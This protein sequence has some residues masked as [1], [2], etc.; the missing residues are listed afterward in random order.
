MKQT[1]KERILQLQQEQDKIQTQLN[2]L[3]Q[4]EYAFGKGPKLKKK[5][6][7]LQ[8]AINELKLML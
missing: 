4:V 3:T 1:P 5:F 7:E 6:W 2:N 8:G